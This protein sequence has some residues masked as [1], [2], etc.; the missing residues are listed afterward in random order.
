MEPSHTRLLVPPSRGFTLVEM[1]VVL[2]IIVVVTLIAIT[3]QGN[4]NRSIILTDTAYTLAFSIREAQSLGLSSRLFSGV[5]NAGYGIHL[6]NAVPTTYSLFADTLP[7]APGSS[8]SGVCPGHSISSGP[9]AKPG[10]CTY[11][12]ASEQV[13]AYSLNRG[14][15]ISRFCGKDLAGVERCS[16]GYLDALDITY[17]RPNT[18]SVITGVRGGSVIALTNAVIYVAAPDGSAERCVSVSKVGQVAVG[19]CP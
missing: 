2:A 5:Q 7:A 3:G 9:D 13:R 15:R 4:F 18:Q 19:T 16:G 12:S 11:D 8:Q 14:F 17:L 6:T 10:N 1:L